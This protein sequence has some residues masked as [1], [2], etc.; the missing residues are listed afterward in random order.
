[1]TSRKRSRLYTVLLLALTAG[2]AWYEWEHRD[3]LGLHE[4]ATVAT[5]PAKAPDDNQRLRAIAA[6]HRSDEQV[7][8]TGCVARLLPDDTEGDR[9]QRFLLAVQDAAL[10]VL[11]AHNVDVGERVPVEVGDEL[12][13][14][15][16]YEWNDE[17]GVL[18][19]THRNPARNPRHP[20]GWIERAGRRYE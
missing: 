9:H 14:S 13:L 7:E 19:W 2:V 8:I 18:H 5:A 17:G 12:R 1:M 20:S 6:A 16:E 3:A 4:P 11:V 15:G 10:V